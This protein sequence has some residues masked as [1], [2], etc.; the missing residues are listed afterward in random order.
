[1]HMMR[2]SNANR[3]LLGD[4]NVTYSGASATT[5]PRLVC[6]RFSAHRSDVPVDRYQAVANGDADHWI[7]AGQI[8]AL[9]D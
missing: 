5:R 3:V 8:A 7:V 1:M 9:T 2:P 6:H 4:L